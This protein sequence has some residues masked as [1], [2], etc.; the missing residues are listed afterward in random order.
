MD[1]GPTEF[2][3]INGQG[4]AFLLVPFTLATQ[5]KGTGDDEAR[6]QL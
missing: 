6:P 3:R 1:I 5:R 4:V 2:E